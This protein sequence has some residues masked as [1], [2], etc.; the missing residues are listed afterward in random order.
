MSIID[1]DSFTQ[2]SGIESHFKGFHRYWITIQLPLLTDV[3]YIH[4]ALDNEL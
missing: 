1:I 4:A 2:L 3:L